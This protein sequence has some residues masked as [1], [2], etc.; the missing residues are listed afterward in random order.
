MMICS[1]CVPSLAATKKA[2]S[3]HDAPEII[4]VNTS[5]MEYGSTHSHILRRARKTQEKIQMNKALPAYSSKPRKRSSAGKA[6]LD[7]AVSCLKKGP[8]HMN[9]YPFKQMGPKETETAAGKNFNNNSP[10]SANSEYSPGSETPITGCPAPRKVIA[11]TGAA[12]DLIGARDLHNKDKQRRLPSLF[13]SVPLTVLLK[14][15]LSSNTFHQPWVK[16]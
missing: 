6:W 16:T 5:C 7:K 2:L 4:Y 14:Q 9:E 13:T 1:P 8:P 15:I 11:D 3:F 12:V 10:Y